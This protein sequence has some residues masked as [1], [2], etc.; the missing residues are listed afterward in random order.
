[1]RLHHIIQITKKLITINLKLII[2]MKKFMLFA[3]MAITAVMGMRAE[4]GDLSVAPEFAFG[5]KCSQPGVGLQIMIEP[6]GNWRIAPELIL[7]FKN[8]NRTSYDFNLNVHYLFHTNEHFALYPLAGI[9]YVNIKT[10]Y[11]DVDGKKDSHKYDRFGGNVG[12]GIQ[13]KFKDYLYFFGEE[14]F[15]F[16]KSNCQ[17]VTILGARIAF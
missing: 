7:Y 16:M 12:G 13:Y 9:S 2:T 1:M 3:L 15:Q 17:A 5:S 10:E 4:E 14:R 6:A 8:K 11:I